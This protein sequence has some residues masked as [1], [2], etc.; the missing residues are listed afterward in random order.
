MTIEDFASCD[1]A[2]LETTITEVCFY[3]TQMT[4]DGNGNI[5]VEVSLK[6]PPGMKAKARAAHN[7]ARIWAGFSWS[8]N[9]VI[10]YERGMEEED[11]VYKKAK[12]EA[13][14]RQATAAAGSGASWGSGD[15]AA[16]NEIADVTKRREIPVITGDAFRVYWRNFKIWKHRD[17][18]PA[19]APTLAQL[20]AL[21]QLFRSSSSY[22]D[23]AIWGNNQSRTA[24]RMRSLGLI[25]G[26]GNTLQRLEFK[27]PPTCED[28][29]ICWMVYERRCS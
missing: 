9:R 6:P 8:R 18:F 21:L 24:K 26:A 19:E 14:S 27:G 22:V 28:W 5:G 13:L 16:M 20:T 25:I 1:P 3:S 23:F 12:L 11:R 15:T 2:E 7:A 10:Q 17:P 29:L 4:D